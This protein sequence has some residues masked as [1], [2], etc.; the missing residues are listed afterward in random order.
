MSIDAEVYLKLI[1]VLS[2]FS[3]VLEASQLWTK[4][5]ICVKQSNRVLLTVL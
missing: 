2:K 4:E 3:K 1:K 5:N